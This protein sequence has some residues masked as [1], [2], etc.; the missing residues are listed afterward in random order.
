MFQ[1][2]TVRRRCRSGCRSI[3]CR[4]EAVHRF[5]GPSASPDLDE[6]ADHDAYHVCDESIRCYVETDAIAFA[7]N[8]RDSHRHHGFSVGRASRAEAG[9]LVLPD[10]RS[11]RFCHCI[12]VKRPVQQPFRVSNQGM[13]PQGYRVAVPPLPCGEPRVEAFLRRCQ[14]PDRYLRPRDAAYA[15]FELMRIVHR[16]WQVNMR[17]LSP[18][19]NPGV[20]P[21]RTYHPGLA[22]RCRP[23]SSDQLALDGSLARLNLPS[24]ESG[25]VVLNDEPV[26]I[27]AHRRPRSSTIPDVIQVITTSAAK[28]SLRVNPS[29]R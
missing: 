4:R 14:I 24:C 6:S 11:R 26:S 1:T 5:R 9:R 22:A 3:A 15:P 7:S 18:C 10:E 17:D 16:L 19:V 8:G 21:A 13:R 28:A 2:K 25:A 23:K 27:G 29:C 12:D 20:S